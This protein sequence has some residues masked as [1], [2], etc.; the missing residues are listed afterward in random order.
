MTAIM[1]D[2]ALKSPAELFQPMCSSQ[3]I[4]RTLSS[5]EETETIVDETL[6]G[7]PADCYHAAGCWETRRQILSIMA[8]KVS[9]KKLRL[10]IPDLSS[11]RFTE[12]K[13]HCLTHGRGAPVSSGQAPVMRVSTAQIDHF[14]TFI[15]SA[16]VIQDLPFG[17]RTITLSSK[18]TIKVPNV[19]RT[20][21]PERLVKQYLAYC[22]E[23]GFKALSRSTLLRTL[24]VCAASV[25]KSLQGLDY[26]SSSGAE[27]F[28]DLCKVAEMLGDAGQGMGWA[29]QQETNL[30]ESKHYLKSDYKVRFINLF[31]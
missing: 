13:R 30:R 15:T 14:I 5:D 7:A 25:R 2:I 4:Q 26:I 3:A 24:S 11:C 1:E 10:W 16:H 18:E 9:F 22:E 6:L 28:D 19:I 20:M 23:T 12:A 21:V 17:E 29:K 31:V 27:A 8:D